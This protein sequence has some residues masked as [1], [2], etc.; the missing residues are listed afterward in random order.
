M[1]SPS[2][3]AMETKLQIYADREWGENVIGDLRS[4][5]G[6]K[7]CPESIWRVERGWPEHLDKLDAGK[8]FR[9]SNG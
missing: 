4:V 8:H 2:R 6:G 7:A 3:E 5:I 1:N 9:T